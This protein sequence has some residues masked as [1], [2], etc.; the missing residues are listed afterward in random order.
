MNTLKKD[1]TISSVDPQTNPNIQPNHYCYSASSQWI[2]NF[3]L[4]YNST[5]IFQMRIPLMIMLV[6]L[7]RSLIRSQM[8]Q[9]LLIREAF[10]NLDKSLALHK[11]LKDIYLRPEENQQSTE[12]QCLLKC[13]VSSLAPIVSSFIIFAFITSIVLS[14]LFCFSTK[15][16]ISSLSLLFFY[17]NN[18]FY[19]FLNLYYFIFQ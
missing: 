11:F 15:A 18:D 14:P 1:L 9:I 13:S 10:R 8:S 16:T 19:L 2:T 5:V 12:Y 6:P 17:R 7:I 4:S 3:A